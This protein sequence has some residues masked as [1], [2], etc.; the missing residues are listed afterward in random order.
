MTALDSTGPSKPRPWQVRYRKLALVGGSGVTVN[1]LVFD[2]LLH[3][4][5][6]AGKTGAATRSSETFAVTPQALAGFG[7]SSTRIALRHPKNRHPKN[8]RP[9]PAP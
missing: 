8:R 2:A 6:R 9:G 7:K 5:H 1:F 4:L 3:G